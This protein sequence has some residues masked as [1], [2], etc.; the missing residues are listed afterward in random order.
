MITS[1]TEIHEHV[2]FL[3]R[4]MVRSGR[5]RHPPDIPHPPTGYRGRQSLSSK[6]TD[7]PKPV[8]IA[9]TVCL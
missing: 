1:N 7:Y 6:L 4:M 9:R 3:L 2:K 5:T 8:G